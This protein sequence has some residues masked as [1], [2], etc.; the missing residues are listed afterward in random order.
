MS[1]F[2]RFKPNRRKK[3][4][5]YS[6]NFRK[7]YNIQET[8]QE[9]LVRE[10]NKKETRGQRFARRFKERRNRNRNTGELPTHGSKK[11]RRFF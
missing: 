10:R 7:A 6:K 3:E 5:E 1:I 11:R 4:A 2:K 8:H 9:K